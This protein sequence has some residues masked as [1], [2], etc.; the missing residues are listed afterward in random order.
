MHVGSL[1]MGFNQESPRLL[2]PALSELQS[3][4]RLN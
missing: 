3:C 1:K 4:R 2:F